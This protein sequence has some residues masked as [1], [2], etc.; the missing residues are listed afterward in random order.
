MT[1]VERLSTFEAITQRHSFLPK[2]GVMP[3]LQLPEMYL[4]KKAWGMQGRQKIYVGWNAR[5]FRSGFP[6]FAN[7]L[8]NTMIRLCTGVILRIMRGASGKS[9]ANNECGYFGCKGKKQIS[10]E[11]LLSRVSGRGNPKIQEVGVSRQFQG[12]HMLSSVT[13]R[14]ADHILVTIATGNSKARHQHAVNTL[15]RILRYAPKGAYL[16]RANGS[17]SIAVSAACSATPSSNPSQFQ[18]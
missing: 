6:K 18:E 3:L 11:K 10:W 9:H 13:T 14:N 15:S 16:L 17:L 12:G 4:L 2:S 7:H 8:R 1:S 5:S